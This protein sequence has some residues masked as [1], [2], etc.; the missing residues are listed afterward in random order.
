MATAAWVG[1]R[2]ELPLVRRISPAEVLVFIAAVA[3]INTFISS[4]ATYI[5]A[6]REE[7]MLA[8]SVCTGLA[9]WVAVEV[10]SR[11]SVLLTVQLY[12]AVTLLIA[13]PWTL[14]LLRRYLKRHAQPAVEANHST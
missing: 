13:L 8:P 10:G 5:R 7:P 11:V 14:A 4:A 3:I 6:H 9:V 1:E 2:W 12:A